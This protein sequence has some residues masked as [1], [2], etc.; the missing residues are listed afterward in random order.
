MK[1]TISSKQSEAEE[2]W[3]KAITAKGGRDRLYSVR[4]MAISAR[5]DYAMRT[6]KKNQVRREELFV[7][8]N[9]YWMYEDYSPD[10]FGT[11]MDMWDYGAGLHYSGPPGSPE[12]KLESL[13]EKKRNKALD[14]GQ[15]F[16]LMETQW[17]K[18][19]PTRATKDRIR[20][21]D[22]DII[23]TVVN[24]RRVDFAMDRKTHL[25]I[26]L[27]FHDVV[28]NKTYINKIFLAHYV[29]TEGIKV[30]TRVTLEDG[31]VEES[32]IRFNV[33]YDPNLFLRP[34]TL[35]EVQRVL[36]WKSGE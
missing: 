36:R 25:P 21:T 15:I 28:N 35:S 27:S 22:V 26:R 13:D 8:P 24:G 31:S 4:N 32:T 30:P 18:P 19:V 14:N 23:Q 17:L 12:T 29:D 1:I 20:G 11:R 7:L 16:L 9:K 34:P 10:V 33:D 5:A 3:E 6:G 2:L